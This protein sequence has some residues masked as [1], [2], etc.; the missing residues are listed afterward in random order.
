MTVCGRHL[1]FN[2]VAGKP[3]SMSRDVLGKMISKS[4]R[5]PRCF[6][7]QFASVTLFSGQ[8]ITAAP[9]GG[10]ISL[11]FYS[12][13]MCLVERMLS[14]NAGYQSKKFCGYCAF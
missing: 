2:Y 13:A 10:A 14:C 3:F 9:R 6:Y 11:R 5:T 7:Q 8:P 12:F 4:V 1:L